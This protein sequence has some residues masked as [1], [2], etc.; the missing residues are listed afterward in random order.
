MAVACQTMGDLPAARRYLEEAL[1][2]ARRL[3]DS[4]SVARCLNNLASVAHVS[5]ARAVW[6]AP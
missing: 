6:V 5:V 4:E 2:E 1:Q 3:G